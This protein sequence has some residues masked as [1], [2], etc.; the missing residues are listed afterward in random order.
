MSVPGKSDV[1]GGNWQANLATNANPQHVAMERDTVFVQRDIMFAT[2]SANYLNVVSNVNSFMYDN[3]IQN[4]MKAKH[5][6]YVPVGPFQQDGIFN[7][8]SG[9]TKQGN[10]YRQWN[11]NQLGNRISFEG[12][13]NCAQPHNRNSENFPLGN[14]SQG[15]WSKGRHN[16]RHQS[17]PPQ[18]KKLRK[19][20]Q[21]AERQ[22]HS[23]SPLE[24]EVKLLQASSYLTTVF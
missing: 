15:G 4:G 9:H 21:V 17:S 3:T 10:D 7:S 14:F 1:F 11:V 16:L 20:M 2:N 12:N 22:D 13:W 8:W 5:S 6:Q 24:K 18:R 19:D 23:K